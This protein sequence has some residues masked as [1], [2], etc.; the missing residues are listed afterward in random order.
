[1]PS[2]PVG[3]RLRVAELPHP[4]DPLAIAAREDDRSCVVTVPGWTLVLTE[5][6]ADVTDLAGLSATADELGWGEPPGGLPFTGLAAGYLS[7]DLSPA[8]LDLP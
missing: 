6:V 3:T 5:P 4:V 7:D 1:V 2:A 8:L